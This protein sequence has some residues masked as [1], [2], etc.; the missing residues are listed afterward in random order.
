MRLGACPFKLND[1]EITGEEVSLRLHGKYVPR[2]GLPVVWEAERGD[3]LVRPKLGAQT[4]QFGYLKMGLASSSI[5]S[6]G[7]LRRIAIP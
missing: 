3:L 2:N 1:F 5:Y 7:F 4:E 6:L